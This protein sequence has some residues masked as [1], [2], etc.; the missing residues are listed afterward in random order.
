MPRNDP[1][2]KKA[3][4]LNDPA[5][6]VLW[7]DD[8]LLV[9]NKPAGLLTTQHGY[10]PDQPFLGG[11]LT[12]VYGSIWTIHRLDR[13]TSGVIAFARN[14]D[15]HRSL[16]TQF[17]QRQTT[18]IYHAL[19]VGEPDWS[20]MSIDLPL[21][22]NGDRQHRTVIDRREGKSSCTDVLVLER[23]GGYALVEARPR[24]GRRH[25]IRAHLAARGYPVVAD[26]LYGDGRM[27]MLS[28][29]KPGYK[30]SGK[31]ESALLG[32]LGLHARELMFKHPSDGRSVQ[33]QAPYQ[34]DFQRTLR[35][36]HK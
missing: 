11:M 17:E 5:Q 12:Q 9:I 23:L 33:F 28:A 30:P 8:D 26:P 34:K 10:D 1:L 3:K 2:N 22:V 4:E 29:I 20:E 7:I 18:K 31:G 6:W 16:N 35:Q 25:Q 19:I 13:D 14:A 36:L 15:S 27:L 21:R 24:S 32:R